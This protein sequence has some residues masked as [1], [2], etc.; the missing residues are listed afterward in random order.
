VV[1]KEVIGHTRA[2]VDSTRRMFVSQ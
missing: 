1:E 2:V